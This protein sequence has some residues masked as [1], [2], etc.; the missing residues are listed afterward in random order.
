M[1][2]ACFF[3][4]GNTLICKSRGIGLTPS[5]V[6]DLSSLRRQGIKLGVCSIRSL[7]MA[8]ESLKGFDFDFY[9]LFDGAVIYE[10][11][12][13]IY[14]NPIEV[15]PEGYKAA[16]DDNGVHATD[17][18]AKLDLEARGFAVTDCLPPKG[19]V[20]AFAFQKGE[21]PIGFE[22]ESWEKAEIDVCLNKGV[23]KESAIRHLQK[24]HGWSD[25]EIA[26]FGDGPNDLG[27][28]SAFPR[29]IAMAGCPEEVGYAASFVT[30]FS[31]RNGVG[32]AL[33][34]L[35]LLP[36][37]YLLF[38]ESKEDD[39]GGVETHA[40]YL[41]RYLWDKGDVYVISHR[42]RENKIVGTNMPASCK[43]DELP[44][45]LK[46]REVRILFNSGHW[47]EEMDEIRAAFPKSRIL[48]R[49]GGNEIPSAPLS[50]MN[51]PYAERKRYWAEAINRNV[52]ILITNSRFTEK[53]LESLG[54]KG[55][56]L[57]LCR[58][59]VPLKEIEA[60]D[61][62]I[63]RAGLYDGDGIH[64][65]CS[66]RFVP[67]K[68][69][70]L[71]LE[72]FL[73]LPE[74]YDLTL[75]GDGPDYLS[76]RKRYENHERIRFLGKKS[77][78]EVMPYI[79][80]AD[81]YLQCSGNLEYQVPDGSYI[82][83]EGMGRTALEAIAAKTYIVSTDSGALKE[84]IK[85]GRG[86]V[87]GDSPKEI[88]EAI[89][90]APYRSLPRDKDVDGFDFEAIFARY[91]GYWRRPRIALV[92][93]KFHGIPDG[94]GSSMI[95]SI[96]KSFKG[97]ADLDFYCLRTPREGLGGIDE[98]NHYAF[99]PNP[100][101][102]GKFKRRIVS[103]P[104]YE[105][106]MNEL[107]SDYDEVV[108]VHT[109]K[110]FGFDGKTLSKSVIF[111]MFNGFDYI[112]SGEEPPK[113]YFDC[114]KRVYDGAR[115]IIVPSDGDKATL[116]ER[117][118][119][120][121][122]K[123]VVVPRGI[124]EI[125]DSAIPKRRQ[126]K[127]QLNI[128]MISS[129]KPQKNLPEAKEIALAL[130]R[131][132]TDAKL[133]IYGTI[134]EK[135]IHDSLLADANEF[136][137]FMGSLSQA[138]LQ[139]GLSEADFLLCSS[140]Q[141]TFGRC[142]YEGALSRVPCI[143]SSRLERIKAAFGDSMAFYSSVKE[144]VSIIEALNTNPERAESLA[145]KAYGIAKDYSYSMEQR[146]LKSYLNPN[147]GLF[148]FGTRPE[149]IKMLPV[150]EALRRRDIPFVAL[151]T[152]QHNGLPSRIMEEAGVKAIH[153][154]A[155]E[156]GD[157]DIISERWAEET[158]SLLR[159]TPSYICVQGDTSSAL[160]GAKLS[161]KLGVPLFYV[162]SGLRSFDEA[163]PY[164]EEIIRKRIS[165][166]AALNFAPSEKEAGNLIAENAR[167]VYL[168]GNPFVDYLMKNT[169]SE[170]KNVVVVTIHRRENLQ[171]LENIFSEIKE[172]CLNHPSIGFV[173]P[174]HPNPIIQKKS[175]LLKGIP[176][177]MLAEP[178][179]PTEFQRLLSSAKAAIT[180]SGGVEEEC[181][182]LGL[183]CLVVR[184][185][186][187]RAGLCMFSPSSQ[188]MSK[189]LDR[190]LSADTPTPDK[191]YGEAGAGERIAQIIEDYVYGKN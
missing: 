9:V 28:I 116:V 119:V 45:L 158:K 8:K 11:K 81:I 16:Y 33:S 166:D 124:S 87:C 140:L 161:L 6:N 12:N 152:Y 160:S 60:I 53:R 97:M 173:F 184:D 32:N 183:P 44:I 29:S 191:R 156:K 34:I 62:A 179:G 84:I 37:A 48:Y 143:V 10:G 103:I 64:L 169:S 185:K 74:G 73:L 78:E 102:I 13:K 104:H 148:V 187:E 168:T 21:A 56:I 55:S 70:G 68:R 79:A 63:S 40:K 151:D 22:T 58:G 181:G 134:D 164:P 180:D 90:S 172:C 170:K 96:V 113:T 18:D 61:K 178:L 1:I 155:L 77:H 57:R 186:T 38:V 75:I 95:A 108:V 85:G 162:E 92:A 89:I 150:L 112:R 46:D 94:G 65:V 59:G 133:F 157:F 175:N 114:E 43:F 106:R 7:E 139:R 117:Y 98:F 88:A 149:A 5:L 31:Y 67:Y 3:D 39:V 167:S 135:P 163:N 72:A 107:L 111:P 126:S 66:A 131:D 129:V 137:K 91:L 19:M 144:A 176:N 130:R 47:I 41:R 174:I 49:T 76:L 69:M 145:E 80:G 138:E 146:R 142:V 120:A 51:L 105:G 101:R 83:C 136:I 141:E 23:S 127:K 4:I 190:I 188:G 30:D 159:F 82:H 42:N 121:E 36:P 71:L 25:G 115:S 50:D 165:F 35:G 27:M 110:A 20:Y 24:R 52:D 99:L 153:L 177:L 189:V 147:P 125:F 123:I 109:S 100:S 171:H 154:A 132:G 17:E 118:G 2:K 14:Q 128:A 15:L 54:V 86:C 26:V 122:E 93:S 182:Y